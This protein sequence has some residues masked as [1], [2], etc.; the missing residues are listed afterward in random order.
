M[1]RIVA[2]LATMAALVAPSALA[3]GGFPKVIQLPQGFQPEGLESGK[4][5]T[6]YVGSRATGAVYKGN[7]RSG[8]G[9]VLVPGAAGRMSLGIELARDRL[10]VAGGSTGKAFV[11]SARTGALV[12]EVQLASGGGATFVN[13]VVVRNGV[14]YFTDSNRAV[15]YR[16]PVGKAIGAV[17]AVT[18][19]GDFQL[20]PGFNLNGIDATANGRTLVA[21]QSATGR[22]FTID[23]RSGATHDIGLGGASVPN[24]DGIMLDGRTLYVVRNQNN[25]VAVVKLAKELTSGTIARTITDPALDVPTG[26]DRFGK[27]LYVVNARFSTAPTPTTP[28]QVV[29]LGK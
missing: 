18:L 24:G 21:V 27:R 9:A 6:F 12:K 13:D 25:L 2:V 26:I 3:K 4:G 14:A 28:Y 29:R 22:L 15:M 11:Y 10:V 17:Q 20:V 23:P 16:L 19:T 8:K 7:L 1:R 5:T